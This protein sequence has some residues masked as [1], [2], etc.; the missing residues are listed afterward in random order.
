M[1]RL[2]RARAR[3][4]P[5]IG[6]P[7]GAESLDNLV[8]ARGATVRGEALRHEQLRQRLEHLGRPH[9]PGDHNRQTFP[10]ILLDDGQDLQRSPVGRPRRQQV[11]RPHVEA[12]RGPATH[13]RPVGEPQPAPVGL[14]LGDFQPFPPPPP[15]DPFGIHRPP[16]PPPQPRD[17]PIPIPPI[18][19]RQRDDPFHHP[20]LIIRHP[21][22]M[23]V[24]GPRRAQPATGPPLGDGHLV[25]D[26]GPRLPASRRAQTCPEGTSVRIAWSRAGSA[27]S[28]LSRG[29]SRSSSLSRVA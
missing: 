10:R 3:I 23:P 4:C 29:F 13:T 2:Q 17:P 19:G 21:R 1:G 18:R 24:R 14:F 9:P 8:I 5:S 6:Q 25:A 7:N 11:I 15:F 22:P 16:L 28:C 20:R 12:I 26:S 27:T